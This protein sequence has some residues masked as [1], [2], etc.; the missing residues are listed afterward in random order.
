VPLAT[1]LMDLETLSAV[2]PSR[3]LARPGRARKIMTGTGSHICRRFFGTD[4]VSVRRAV[5]LFVVLT[6]V[7]I[8][9]RS[10]HAD[11]PSYLSFGAGY[12]DIFHEADSAEFRLEYRNKF[13]WWLF[14]PFAGMTVTSDPAFFGYAGVLSDFYFGDRIVVTPSVAAGPYLRGAGKDLG[15]VFE[16]RSGI[17]VAYRFNDR[18]RLGVLFYHISN[19]GLGDDQNPGAEAL[20]LNYSI[21]LN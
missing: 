20:S 21:P 12:Y 10:G 18:S 16:I 15:N 13:R 5:A 14:K 11:D 6:V 19:A 17:E 3:S 4:A 7:S 9:P 2:C 8:I 1:A